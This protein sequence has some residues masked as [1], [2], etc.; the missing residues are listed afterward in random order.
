MRADLDKDVVTGVGELP[1][2]LREKDGRSQI[3]N[4][5]GTVEAR[6]V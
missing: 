4:P 6:G 1:D 5:V 2:T 3:P